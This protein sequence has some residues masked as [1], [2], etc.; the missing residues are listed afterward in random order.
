MNYKEKSIKRIEKIINIY[1]A[2]Y[3]N[4]NNLFD[5]EYKRKIYKKESKGRNKNI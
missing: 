4:I 2:Q 1:K 3:N 5:R